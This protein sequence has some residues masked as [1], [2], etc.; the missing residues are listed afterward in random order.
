SYNSR[1]YSLFET[2]P[3]QALSILSPVAPL[4]LGSTSFTITSPLF[5]HGLIRLNSPLRTDS[6]YSPNEE[7]LDWVTFQT[8]L[9]GITETPQGN[10]DA[11]V[12]QSEVDEDEV[13]S[14]ISWWT[15]F[16]FPGYGQ[17]V[18]ES[19]I[20]N[21]NSKTGATKSFIATPLHHTNSVILIRDWDEDVRTADILHNITPRTII[22]E[23]R[24]SLVDLSSL[25]PSPMSNMPLN[26]DDK[27]FI[28]MG[29]NLMHD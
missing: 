8:A 7:Q 18:C 9:S 29:F 17:L 25:P 14:I 2:R 27:D 6:S 10:Y 13:D 1:L 12:L 23:D 19:D 22:P 16:G 5:S 21:N 15:S 28:P 3:R 4:T 26:G 20:E 11:S 24:L